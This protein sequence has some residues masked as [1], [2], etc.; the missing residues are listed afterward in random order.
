MVSSINSG[1]QLPPPP[2][3]ASSSNSQAALSTEQISEID[4]IL[5][6][7]SADELSDEDAQS[8]V[9]QF[10]SAGIA[11]SEELA[12]VL[13]ESGFDARAIGE[14]AG[15]EGGEPPPPPQT[16]VTDSEEIVNFLEDLLEGYEEQL[17]DEDKDSILAAIQDRFGTSGG[18]SLVDLTA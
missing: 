8:I 16:E 2:P 7:F 10:A 3:P 15:V 13:A 5:S 18:N 17:S 12:S 11:P 14:A 1:N 6:N 9:E 4:E